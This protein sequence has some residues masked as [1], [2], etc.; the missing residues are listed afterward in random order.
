MKIEEELKSGK[1]RSAKHKALVNVLFTE[2]WF[3]NKLREIFK[4]FSITSQQYNVLRILNGSYPKFMNPKAIKEVMIDKNPDLTRLCDRLLS[5]GLIE[6]EIN[7]SNRRK[8]DIRINANGISML[9]KMDPSIRAIEDNLTG[10][11]EKEAELLSALLD[12]MRS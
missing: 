9:K 3:N 1:F 7:E 4:D 6:R 2:V 11:N 5:M 12:K 8:M 10:L